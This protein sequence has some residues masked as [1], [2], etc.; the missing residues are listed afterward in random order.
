MEAP[1][2]KTIHTITFPTWWRGLAVTVYMRRCSAITIFLYI[3]D[4]EGVLHARVTD[5]CSYITSGIECECDSKYQC[6]VTVGKK[7]THLATTYVR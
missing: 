7:E 5:G 6:I 4:R 3:I 1:N 2:Y